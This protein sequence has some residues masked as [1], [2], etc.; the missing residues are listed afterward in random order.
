MEDAIVSY[1]LPN[2]TMKK[3]IEMER[4]RLLYHLRSKLAND[5]IRLELVVNE[6]EAKKFAY[7][8]EEKYAKFK[9]KNPAL[10]DLRKAFDLEL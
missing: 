5:T 1:T 7:T 2:H 4:E 3:E 10:E 8:P 6:E 9:A